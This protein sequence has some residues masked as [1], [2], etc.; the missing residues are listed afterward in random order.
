MKYLFIYEF[1]TMTQHDNITDDDI[2]AVEDGCLQIF[3]YVD[4]RFFELVHK[5]EWVPVE[6]GPQ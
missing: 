2:E 5:D 1:E 4:G 6:D 3:K